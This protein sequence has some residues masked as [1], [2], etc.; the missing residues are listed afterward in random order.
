MTAPQQQPG[1]G[2][3]R[4]TGGRARRNRGRDRRLSVRAVRR[5][6]PDLRKLS[7]AIVA[8]ALAQAEAEAQAQTDAQSAHTEPAVHHQPDTEAGND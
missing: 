1:G 6:P 2:K 5:D 7:R 3:D 4:R 8:I